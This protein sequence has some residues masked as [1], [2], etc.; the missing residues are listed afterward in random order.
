NV[1]IAQDGGW[2]T[3]GDTDGMSVRNMMNTRILPPLNTFMS[4]M[5][6][7]QGRAVHVVIFG[8]FARS[9]PGS[10]HQ[11]NLTA[12]VIGKNVKIGTTGKVDSSVG[13]AAGTPST[14]GL[15]GYLAAVTKAGSMFGGNP[16]Q[17]VL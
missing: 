3:H 8:D 11:G 12:T 7:A 1:V 6:E 9:L 4:R 14:D 2:D 15:W 16:H 17:L 10:D 5:L 13:L